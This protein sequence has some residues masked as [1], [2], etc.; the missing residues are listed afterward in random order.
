MKLLHPKKFTCRACHHLPLDDPC[1]RRDDPCHSCVAC[2][3]KGAPCYVHFYEE[4]RSAKKDA[5]GRKE[6]PT[7]DRWCIRCKGLAPAARCPVHC[8]I[9]AE[10]IGVG[11]LRTQCIK[12]CPSCGLAEFRGGFCPLHFV[13]DPFEADRAYIKE[14]RLG[15]PSPTAKLK[16][17]RQLVLVN[18]WWDAGLSVVSCK[19]EIVRWLIDRKRPQPV[20][21]LTDT[22]LLELKYTR[23]SNGDSFT[24]SVSKPDALIVRV[25]IWG[26]KTHEALPGVIVEVVRLRATKLT[27]FVNEPITPWNKK[28]SAWSEA[29]E[30]LLDQR[31]ARFTLP[32]SKETNEAHKQ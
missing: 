6:W 30:Q 29:L 28:H 3:M 22:Q 23:S 16:T 8:D 14:I 32:T 25:G 17:D 21:M 15:D 27:L 19:P 12:H 9:C 26:G 5:E 24:D 7:R 10:C 13:R 18:G 2:V 1:T 4:T 20:A 11:V 31:G